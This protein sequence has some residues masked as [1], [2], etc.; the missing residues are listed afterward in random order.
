MDL[1]LISSIKPVM[2]IAPLL[3]GAGVGALGGLL[4]GLFRPKP[5]FQ[6]P[7][8][9]GMRGARRSVSDILGYLGPERKRDIPAEIKQYEG[10]YLGRTQPA[11]EAAMN[12]ALGGAYQ[13]AFGRGLEGTGRAAQQ[14]VTAL[15]QIGAQTAM[16]RQ[17]AIDART[18]MLENINRQERTLIANA[19]TQAYAG[20]QTFGLSTS[21][22]QNAIE[23]FKAGQPSIIDS[24]ISGIK[25]GVTAAGGAP[26][27]G[28]GGATP[29]ALGSSVT[30][31]AG[32]P[33][34]PTMGP[35]R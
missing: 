6:D 33:I 7:F 2:A 20:G 15:G 1:E 30:P 25:G 10:E 19:I 8:A 35:A 22:M 14:R 16:E 18:V 32:G 4:S 34:G 13:Q 23:S 17:R 9:Q 31:R 11:T 24:I 28:Q 21:R 5:K 27:A 29:N 12:A 26:F 3:I